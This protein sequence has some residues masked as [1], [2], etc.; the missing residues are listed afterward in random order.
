MKIRFKIFLT[1]IGF[2]FF[3]FITFSQETR[4]VEINAKEV[5]ARVDQFLNYPQ[6]LL[7]G[8]I[9]HRNMKGES[10]SANLELMVKGDNSLFVFK[11]R[12]RGKQMK[13]LYNMGGEDIWVYNILALK[14]YHKVDIDKFDPIL[15]TNFNFSDLSNADF[16]TNYDAELIG[17]SYVNGKEVF[18]LTLTPIDGR[19]EYGKIT[20]F[21]EKSDSFPVRIDFHDNDKVFSKSLTFPRM[22]IYRGKKFPI[23]YEML[24]VNRNSETV[25]QFTKYDQDFII[26]DKM[27]RHQ[28]LGSD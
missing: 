27:F 5:L 25:L 26:P 10:Y 18:K 21:V 11:N 9:L 8:S 24:D 2:T 17:D 3:C 22:K 16:Q 7:R 14:L 19:G 13:I 1:I 15:N 23:V 6:G 12:W 28:N 4:N 20:L